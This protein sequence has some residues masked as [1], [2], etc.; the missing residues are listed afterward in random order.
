MVKVTVNSHFIPNFHLKKWMHIGASIF[1]KTNEKSVKFTDTT[2]T[3]FFSQKFYYSHKNDDT[4]EKRLAKFESVISRLIAKIDCTEDAIT[5]TGKDLYLLKL[6]C[7]LCACRQDNT[8][9]VIKYD[10][11]EIYQSNNYLW[12]IPHIHGKDNIIKFTESIVTEFERVYRDKKFVSLE[13]FS[14]ISDLTIFDNPIRMNLKNLHLC[15]LRNA[16]NNIALSDVFAIIENTMDSDH[17]YTYIPISP[18]SALFL[19]KTKYYITVE[20]IFES[21]IRLAQNHGTYADTYLSVIFGHEEF[22]LVCPY[23]LVRSAVHIKEVYLPKTDFSTVTVKIQDISDEIVDRF[24][25]IMYED[26]N[27]FIY[28]DD[29]QLKKAKMPLID[30]IITFN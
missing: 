19:V 10:E 29:N 24:N 8:T 17:L 6:Y 1:D 23:F 21:R 5:L 3:R 27:F 2:S 14:P 25:S 11:S 13:D 30:R 15:I 16:E 18:K 7:Y 20:K 22:K 26:S 12:G 28:K 4:L 9:E